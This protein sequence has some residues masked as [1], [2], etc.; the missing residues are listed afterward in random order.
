MRV[1]GPL[2]IS[3]LLLAPEVWLLLL[4]LVDDWYTTG[5]PL[6]LLLLPMPGEIL[7]LQSLL[8]NDWCTEAM[9][10]KLWTGSTCPS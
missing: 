9:P 7:L 3:L 5:V 2:G 8:V 4:L 10:G 6:P 1:P